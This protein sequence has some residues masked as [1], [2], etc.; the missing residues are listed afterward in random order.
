MD[1][2][3]Y[4]VP[5]LIAMLTVNATAQ[6][7]ISLYHMEVIPQSSML[8]PARAP[9]CNVF[10]GLPCTNISLR[11]ETNIKMSQLFQQVDGQWHFMT[12]KEFDYST[13]NRRFKRNGAREN[14]QL[15]ISVLNFGWR[16]GEG[17]WTVNLNTHIETSISMPSAIFTMLDKGLPDGTRLD[18]TSLRINANAYHELGIG[19]SIQ[20]DEQLSVGGRLKYLS[21]LGAIKTK[22]DKFDVNTGRDAW[23]F[24]VDGNGYLSLPIKMN[25][26]KDGTIHTDSIELKDLTVGQ[27]VSRALPGFHNPGAAIDLGAEYKID[28]NFKVSASVTDLGFIVW[29]KDANRVH[30]KNTYKFDGVEIEFNDFFDGINISDIA[31]DI[32]DSVKN[33]FSSRVS[34]KRFVSGTHPNIYIA[35]EYTPFR[36][37]TVGV[38]SRTTVW[39]RNMTQNFNFTLNMKPYSF[40]SI[41]SGYNIDLKGCITT[42]FGFSI[43]MGPLQ[44]Y[45]MMNGLP[46][47][48]R[49][50]TIEGDKT[51]IPYNLCDLGISTGFNVIVGAKGPKVKK[52]S[53]Y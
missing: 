19:Y 21:G 17:Y 15:N 6:T 28:E 18:F 24:D 39:R 31:G 25:P 40:V 53:K 7:S 20:L 30:A 42:N 12:D 34:S 49:H 48:Y 37:M 26:D 50:L 11:A 22:I 36:F 29:S 8:N 43:N 38:V 9:R 35:G 23:T 46:I 1:M 41:M 33:V 3:R 4:I 16:Q 14:N 51:L 10:V 5:L 2:K 52:N 27:I 13:L 45:L 47:T 44:Y 32:V